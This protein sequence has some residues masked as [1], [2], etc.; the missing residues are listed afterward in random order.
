MTDPTHP[1]R[2]KCACGDDCYGGVSCS[3]ECPR[4]T[5]APFGTCWC[6]KDAI[7]KEGHTPLC[8]DC[9]D[10]YCHGCHTVGED[11]SGCGAEGAR[12]GC[13]CDYCDAEDGDDDA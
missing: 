1:E 4:C 8:D 11:C 13:G 6:G 12:C 2:A 9:L 7:A 5:V 10:R 3:C